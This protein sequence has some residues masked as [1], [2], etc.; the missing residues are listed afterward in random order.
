M[1]YGSRVVSRTESPLSVVTST[2]LLKHFTFAPTSWR[3]GERETVQSN[4]NPYTPQESDH[5]NF[6]PRPM[7]SLRSH[8]GSRDPPL[9]DTRILLHSQSVRGPSSHGG[10]R[11]CPEDILTRAVR[12]SGKDGT[13]LPVGLLV[14]SNRSARLADVVRGART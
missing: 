2:H 14:S 10:G 12:N 8:Q 13:P 7:P 6:L 5:V 9:Q 3:V 1:R 11:K 4:L